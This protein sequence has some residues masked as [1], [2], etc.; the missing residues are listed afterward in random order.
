V[1]DVSVVRVDVSVLDN[2]RTPVDDLGQADFS[3]RVDGVDRPIV[4]FSR[5]SVPAP[6]RVSQAPPESA[7]EPGGPAAAPEPEDKGRLVA[8]LFDRTI[9]VGDATI[10]AR[11]VATALVGALGPDDFAAV[12]RSSGF[13]GE[14]KSQEF[15]QDHRA[16]LD[17]IASPFMG[18]TSP[19]TMTPGGLVEGPRMQ[20]DTGECACGS[21]SLDALAAVAR[22][23]QS[24]VGRRKMLVFI[25]SD[26]P[27][28][29]EDRHCGSVLREA[30]RALFRDLDLS[31]LT[32]HVIDPTGLE[33][34]GI[35]AA[36]LIRQSAQARGAVPQKIADRLQRQGNLAVLP[37]RTGGR[38]VT[39]TNTPE[40]FAGAIL[41][42]SRSYYLLGFQPGPESAGGKVHDIK[43]HVAR[44]GVQ[45]IARKSYV[46]RKAQ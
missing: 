32:V 27:F 23:I 36:S 42:E 20:D 39:N 17:A 24:N 16:L 4:A 35:P 45:V 5:V 15:T 40:A 19:P 14:G 38:L 37:E 13:S 34:G 44:R 46:L 41:D 31:N 11:R 1:G 10:L 26:I 2:H 28:V 6:S 33:A 25:G 22:A 18:M 3:I 43:V 21:C 30:R 29:S 9:P 7:R 8:I 12:L